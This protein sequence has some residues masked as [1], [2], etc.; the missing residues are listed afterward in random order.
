MRVVFILILILLLLTMTSWLFSQNSVKDPFNGLNRNLWVPWNN[1]ASGSQVAVTQGT[2]RLTMASGTD[3]NL[4]LGLKSGYFVEGDFDI[5]VDFNLLTWPAEDQRTGIVT[6]IGGGTIGSWAA[7]ERVRDQTAGNSYAVDFFKTVAFVPTTDTVGKLRLVRAGK[8]YS[9]YYWNRQ[10]NGWTLIKSY[11]KS[12]G[13]ASV[14]L[15][16]WASPKRKTQSAVTVALDNFSATSQSICPMLTGSGTP[17]IGHAIT[18]NLAPRFDA[19]LSYQLACS[20]GT[21]PIQIS[22][23]QLGLSADVLLWMS[24][25][26]VLPTVFQRFS[27]IVDAQGFASA[28]INIPAIPS[29]VGLKIHSAFITMSPPASSGIKSIS[30]TYSFTITI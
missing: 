19:G 8:K 18:L 10:Q 13:I 27:G 16:L 14:S 6:I 28:N 21:G 1:A 11:S 3:V 17:R 30:N 9:G 20:F 24:L 5:Q 26:N 25:N 2:L 4:N 22:N 12:L 7:V 29:I 15:A 23:S